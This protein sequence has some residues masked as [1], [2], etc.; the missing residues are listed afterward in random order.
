MHDSHFR[1]IA[2]LADGNF[3]SG[4][5]LGKV[6]GMSR[7][8]VWKLIKGLADVG[9][10]VHA[11]SGKGYRL[12]KPLDL[13]D[14]TVILASLNQQSHKYLERIEVHQILSSTNEYLMNQAG[15]G[16]PGGTV[17]FAEYQECGR[18]RRGRKWIAPYGSNIPVSLLWRFNEGTSRLSGLSLAV[19]VAIHRALI[20]CGL[21]GAGLKWP[22]DILRGGKKVAGILLEVAGESNGPCYAVIG[23]GVNV[24]MPEGEVTGIE[25]PWTDLRRCGVSVNR[26]IVAGKLLH[27][28]LLAI[29][30][31]L[32]GGLDAFL[33]EWNEWDLMANK[34]VVIVH[35]EQK[36]YGVA[37]GIDA[38]GLLRL[39]DEVGIHTFSSGE[40]S[41]RLQ[42]I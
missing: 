10:D 19:A 34:S 2:Q 5:Q 23:V 38:R 21:S 27:H 33:E 32:E 9:L 28:L 25:Q 31:Y 6:L 17:C 4:E 37:R 35:G 8:A 13:L 29:P 40:V 11:V 1:L 36:R 16:A 15:C 41:L 12:P 22:N 18:G 26:N 20:E 39:E 3:H 42:S 30:Q 14:K 7:A 24:D